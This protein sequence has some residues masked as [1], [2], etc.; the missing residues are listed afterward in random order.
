MLTILA[1]SFWKQLN[2]GESRIPL[3]IMTIGAFSIS[4]TG[5]II[6]FSEG[7]NLATVLGLIGH[8]LVV[9]SVLMIVVYS[10]TL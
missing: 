8:F 9:G 2:F 6:G 10:T 1:A 7:K 5:L 3:A 4:V